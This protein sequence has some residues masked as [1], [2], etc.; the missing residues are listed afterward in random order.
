MKNLL[1]IAVFIT[2]FTISFSAQSQ[3]ILK[4]IDGI[5]LKSGL[6]EY[7]SSLPTVVE[8]KILGEKN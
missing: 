3:Q 4:F 1:P 2:L 8:T 6:M 5:E 7:S